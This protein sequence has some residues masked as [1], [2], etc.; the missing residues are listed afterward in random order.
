[1]ERTGRCMCGAVTYTAALEPK[2]SACHCSMCRRWAGGPYLAAG[3]AKVRFSGEENITVIKSSGWAERGFC[4]KCGSSLFYRL[5]AGPAA[6]LTTVGFGSLD[7]PSG[8]EMVREW[9]CDRKPDA[10]AFE[11]DRER[12]T[13]EQIK[14]IFGGELSSASKGS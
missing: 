10:Y 1:M 9:F 2:L 4:N 8:F 13:T 7:D 14:A 11:G 6:G 12:L 5:T 3:P